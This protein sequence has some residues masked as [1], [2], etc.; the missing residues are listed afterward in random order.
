MARETAKLLLGVWHNR[1]NGFAKDIAADTVSS[2]PF[3]ECCS[4]LHNAAQLYTSFGCAPVPVYMYVHSYLCLLTE[5]V[6]TIT[7][8]IISFTMS[9]QV[10]NFLDQQAFLCTK[11]TPRH[12][13]VTVLRCTTLCM[14]NVHAACSKKLICQF[15]LTNTRLCWGN[16]VCC[17]Y[18]PT[19]VCLEMTKISYPLIVEN[20]QQEF[21]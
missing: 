13:Y 16:K 15:L 11:G 9:A 3:C 4:R 20:G 17:M 2:H 1:D 7:A 12:M 18:W 19:S 8:I 5:N 6:V 10:A 21:T 14:Q